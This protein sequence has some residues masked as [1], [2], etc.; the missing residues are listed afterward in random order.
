MRTLRQ[1]I[2]TLA[3]ALTVPFSAAEA[4]D[5]RMAL[6]LS[7][8]DAGGVLSVTAVNGDVRTK[9]DPL[10]LSLALDGRVA[11]D[12]SG[13]RVIASELYL[14]QSGRAAGVTKVALDGT[15]QRALTQSGTFAFD[16]DSSGPL[17]KDAAALCASAGGRALPAG[18]AARFTMTVPV[19]WRVTTGRF[20]F[21]SF[22]SRGVTPAEEVLANP[23]YYA[24]QAVEETEAAAIVDVTCDAIAMAAGPDLKPKAAPAAATATAKPDKAKAAQVAKGAGAS[25][26]AKTNTPEVQRLVAEVAS[27]D[28][29]GASKPVTLEAA[30]EPVCDGGMVRETGSG[31]EGASGFVCLCPGHTVRRETSPGAFACTRRLAR[32]R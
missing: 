24:E 2:V 30:A 15:P 4:G 21:R 31:V 26:A 27:V 3:A 11:D 22:A 19:V 28:E 17:A 20:N 7:A 32:G 25:A 13:Y 6:R 16:I 18:T 10:S 29:A 14:K 23:D 12:A 8:A 1:T 9:N 5:Q